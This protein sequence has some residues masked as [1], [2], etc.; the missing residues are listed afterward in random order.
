M[1]C[2]W[3]VAPTDT[4]I[5]A[6]HFGCLGGGNH[7]RIAGVQGSSYV[8]ELLG[9]VELLRW[10]LAWTEEEDCGVG[11]VEHWMDNQVVVNMLNSRKSKPPRKLRAIPCRQLW[12]EV[13]YSLECW[14]G[15][16]GEWVAGWTRGHIE[17]RCA[18]EQRWN[19][20]EWLLNVQADGMA[21]QVRRTGQ[22]TTYRRMPKLSMKWIKGGRWWGVG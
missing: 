18:D 1:T 10:L 16:G 15:R 8:S 7:T 14:R 2:G 22:P 4:R 3:A 6:G 5:G 13:E 21:A 11:K 17:R 20:R 19:Q 9:V 12:A